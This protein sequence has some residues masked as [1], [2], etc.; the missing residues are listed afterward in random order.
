MG[1]NVRGNFKYYLFVLVLLFGFSCSDEIESEIQG[2]IATNDTANEPYRFPVVAIKACK[3]ALSNYIPL[4]GDIDTKVKAEVFPDIAGEVM[5]LNI[6]LGSYVKEGQIIATVD[7]SRPGFFYLKS[8]VRAP[9]SGYVLAINCRVGERVDPQ[10]SIA[11]IGRMDVMQIKTYVSEKYVLDIKVGNNAIIELESYPNEK[12]KA[13]ISE[14]SPVLDFKSRTAVVYL[15][16]IG[17]NTG[18]VIGMFA[19]IKLV[20]KHLDNV[21]KIPSRA[22]IEREGKLCVFR[23]NTDTKTVER[24]FPSIDFEVDNIMSIREGINEGDLIVIEGISSLSDGAYVDIVDIQDGLD[25]E[26]NV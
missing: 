12:F 15:E 9:M 8:P 14:V 23:L 18:M 21:V 24:V 11:L 17:N 22:F 2:D 26:D 25:I 7:P 1:F 3:G 13:K 5:S 19:K 6:R 16:P 4:N 20:T 10:K